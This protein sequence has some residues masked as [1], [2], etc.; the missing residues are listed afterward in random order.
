MGMLF[1]LSISSGYLAKKSYG[2]VHSQPASRFWRLESSVSRRYSSSLWFESSD[3]YSISGTYTGVGASSC[4][5]TRLEGVAGAC[6]LVGTRG[7]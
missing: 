5:T 4:A 3:Q 1:Q 7:G 2:K 6:P